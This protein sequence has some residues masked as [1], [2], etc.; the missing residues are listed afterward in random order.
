M[1]PQLGNMLDRI[2]DSA[3]PAPPAPGGGKMPLDG[4]EGLKEPAS[5]QRTR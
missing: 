4:R 3:G 5:L 2:P 1:I